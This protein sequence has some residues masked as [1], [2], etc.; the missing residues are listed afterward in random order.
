MKIAV[1]TIK[2]L[3]LLAIIMCLCSCAGSDAIVLYIN[4]TPVTEQ[5]FLLYAVEKKATT[6]GYFMD[7][8]SAEYGD[9]FWELDFNGEKPKDKLK[10]ETLEEIVTVKIKQQTAVE[11]GALDSCD[12]EDIH[13]K[14]TTE[15]ERRS[16]TKSD[17][18]VVYGVSEYSEQQYLHDFNAKLEIA[19]KNV[20]RENTEITTD[21]L[22]NYYEEIKEEFYRFPEADKIRVYD[23][24]SEDSPINRGSEYQDFNDVEDNV[25]TKYI[26]KIYNNIID[27]ERENCKIEYTDKFDKINFEGI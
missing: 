6:A 17:G 8:Y 27:A 9:G 18:G 14:F 4:D 21:E 11:Y 20:L 7:K 1:M 15:N 12:Y 10:S 22:R 13:K 24:G 5:E 3:A 25:L 2:A 16:K 26:D 23:T 19:T